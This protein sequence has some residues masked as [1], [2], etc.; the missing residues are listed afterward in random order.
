MKKT[1]KYEDD[2]EQQAEQSHSLGYQQ[3]I[4]DA[5]AVF[6][7]FFANDYTGVDAIKELKKL[8]EGK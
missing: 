8:K 4:N 5:I 6:W 3:G 1:K 2:L 7:K